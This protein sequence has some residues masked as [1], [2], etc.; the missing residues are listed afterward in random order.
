MCYIQ[1]RDCLLLFLPVLAGTD[2]V[3]A[4]FLEDALGFGFW[5]ATV[6]GAGFAWWEDGVVGSAN[7]TGW[8]SEWNG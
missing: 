1:A 5:E 4:C 7:A 8:M 3:E 2:G 6:R